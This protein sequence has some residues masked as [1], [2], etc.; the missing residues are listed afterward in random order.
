MAE[1]RAAQTVQITGHSSVRLTL[2]TLIH[3]ARE[4]SGTIGIVTQQIHIVKRPAG[5]PF[6]KPAVVRIF[7]YDV[8]QRVGIPPDP[9]VPGFVFEQ[10]FRCLCRLFGRIP[11]QVYIELGAHQEQRRHIDTGQKPFSF[12]RSVP[13]HIADPSLKQARQAHY[14]A[15]LLMVAEQQGAYQIVARIL[16]KQIADTAAQQHGA[17]LF[18]A[19]ERLVD[20][21]SRTRSRHI[22]YVKTLQ[23]L[24]VSLN[25]ARQLQNHLGGHG[26]KLA[27]KHGEL[28][29]SRPH[30]H[31][32]HTGLLY[33]IL[34]HA[35]KFLYAVYEQHRAVHFEQSVSIDIDRCGKL[36]AFQQPD[37]T[38]EDVAD[39]SVAVP[40]RGESLRPL[41][42]LHTAYYGTHALEI[43]CGSQQVYIIFGHREVPVRQIV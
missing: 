26:R 7:L 29:A 39:Y 27:L 20:I 42:R 35:E 30:A 15:L 19:Y 12:G 40:Q 22:E 9:A 4:N 13:Y 25:S 36:H 37:Q 28:P 23:K 5:H 43:T 3:V 33:F 1:K 32:R 18:L 8:G 38:R 2:G 21:L 31:L 10:V 17:C 34:G 16:I 6:R 14:L 41:A 11:G 24:L